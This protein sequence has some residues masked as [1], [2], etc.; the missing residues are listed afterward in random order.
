MTT[1]TENSTVG[2]VAS[3]FPTSIPLFQQAGIDFCCGGNKKLAEVCRDKG[4][5]LEA[6]IAGVAQSQLPAESAGNRDWSS[7]TL[8]D[9]IDHILAKHHAYLYNEMPRLA[10]TLSK[11]TQVHGKNHGESLQSLGRYY[12]GLMRELE[13]HMAK[14]ENILFPLIRQLEQAGSR[15]S[16]V[17]PGMPVGGP[18]HMMEYEHEAA[19]NALREMRKATDDYRLPDD[20]CA[21]Y[22]A[23][24]DGLKAMEADLHQHIHL[25]NNILFP[26][27]L[28]LE[29]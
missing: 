7:A 10:A 27:A 14:E 3:S 26:R 4:L 18:I 28:E 13:Q 21:T 11:V 22:R 8:S 24:F 25:E 6:L 5:S 9:L 2:E 29:K 17:R 20:A 16:G 1:I 19:G 12:S 23:L 15:S